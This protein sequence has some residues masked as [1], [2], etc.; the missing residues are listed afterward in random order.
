MPRLLRQNPMQMFL[1]CVPPSATHQA[2]KIIRLGK[3]ARLAD[4]P[5]LISAQQT[6]DDLLLPHQTGQTLIGP[7]KLSLSFTWPWRAN[8]T[9]RSRQRGWVP[10]TTKPDCSN[11]AKMIEDRLVALRFIEDDAKVYELHVAKS[12]GDRPGIGIGIVPFETYSE[13]E[14]E[15]P[16][17]EEAA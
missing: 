14:A 15:A 8:E 4:K 7:V 5:E 13:R 2:K 17:A 3:F 12:W 11:L 9:R 6:I 1:I 16:L 10:K